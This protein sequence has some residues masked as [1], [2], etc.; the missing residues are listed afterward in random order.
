[1]GGLALVLIFTTGAV[2]A[3]ADT[4]FP[5]DSLASGLAADFSA[6]EHFL[7]RLRLIHP[8]LAV[9]SVAAGLAALRVRG[10]EMVSQG[11]W[12]VWLALVQLGAGGLNV[13]LG[14]PLWLQIVHLA[15]ADG[16]WIAYVWLAARVLDSTSLSSAAVPTGARQVNPSQ[17]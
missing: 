7:T 16:L 11:R 8:V 2:T 9:A 1:V 5:S 13:I 10:I 4:L 6:A 17:T 3:L 15:L 14:T 12:V